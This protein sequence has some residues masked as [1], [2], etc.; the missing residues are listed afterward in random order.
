MTLLCEKQWPAFP[1]HSWTTDILNFLVISW[2]QSQQSL[3][4]SVKILACL[5][6][7]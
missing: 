3:G 2:F 7:F 6:C 4:D 1:G 5:G